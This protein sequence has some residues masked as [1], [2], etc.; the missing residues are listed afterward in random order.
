LKR[1]IPGI[2]GPSRLVRTTR[3]DVPWRPRPRARRHV[4]AFY[5]SQLNFSD[6]IQLYIQI[7]SQASSYVCTLETYSTPCGD[8]GPLRRVSSPIGSLSL[9]LSACLYMRPRLSWLQR[10][11]QPFSSFFNLSRLS[12][13]SS[14]LA[15]ASSPSPAPTLPAS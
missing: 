14:L 6:K 3:T 4:G 13:S 2:C 8:G 9:S 7:I 1:K 12:S 11:H 5:Y 10:G 15:P